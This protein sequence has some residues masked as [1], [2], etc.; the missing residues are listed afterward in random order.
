MRW[1][2]LYITTDEHSRVTRLTRK[3]AK[4]TGAVHICDVDFNFLNKMTNK[5]LLDI[6]TVLVW[7]ATMQM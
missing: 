1:S 7:R 4:R 6:Y 2:D 5:E 3:Q